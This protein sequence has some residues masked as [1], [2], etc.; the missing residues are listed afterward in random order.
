MSEVKE[1]SSY[2]REVLDEVTV[3][4][5]KAYESLHISPVLWDGLL[6]DSGDFN[7]VYCNLVLRDN[8]S[9]VFNLLPVE[10][11]FLQTEE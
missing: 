1:G 10:F 5:N 4:V 2:S 6:T 8:Q 9:E 3:E 11:T 7:R